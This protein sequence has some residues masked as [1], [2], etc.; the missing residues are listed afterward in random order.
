[1]SIRR[2]AAT[3]GAISLGLVAL[4]ACDKP[5]AQATVTVGTRTVTAEAADKSATPG[6]RA[7]G[8]VVDRA[9]GVSYVL[10][11]VRPEEPLAVARVRL[12]GEDG[13]ELPVLH[14]LPQPLAFPAGG[15]SWLVIAFVPPPGGGALVAHLHGPDGAVLDV[16][17]KDAPP[18]R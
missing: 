11:R 17:V 12:T 16:P 7:A 6:V 5:T 14:V 10:L 3:I 2:A 15:R 1:M 13:S 4:T 8:T 18:G 9:S